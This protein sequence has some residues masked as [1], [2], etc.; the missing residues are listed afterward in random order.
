MSEAILIWDELKA[1]G[2]VKWDAGIA[3]HGGELSRKPCLEEAIPEL[4][5]LVHYMMTHRNQVARAQMYLRECISTGRRDAAIAALNILE[6]G[7]AE[8]ETF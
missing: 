4:I 8:G 5:D 6:T 2:V 7:N 1:R 3:E